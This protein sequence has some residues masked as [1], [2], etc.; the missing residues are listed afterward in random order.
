MSRRHRDS[1]HCVK[2]GH[3]LFS[4]STIVIGL[5]NRVTHLSSG[6]VFEKHHLT[7]IV[8]TQNGEGH[9][10]LG[11]GDRIEVESMIGNW[12]MVEIKV[13]VSVKVARNTVLVLPWHQPRS[14]LNTGV[15]SGT[16]SS[17]VRTN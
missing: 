4:R 3:L 9:I 12:V 13:G 5:L 7:A 1:F 8:R 11:L 14:S 15:Q 17:C 10:T 16:N 2:S 6:F